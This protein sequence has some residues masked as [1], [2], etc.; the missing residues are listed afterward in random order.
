MN[1]KFTNNCKTC[2]FNLYHRENEAHNDF[3]FIIELK[4][5]DPKLKKKFSYCNAEIFANLA[6]VYC[7]AKHNL[8]TNRIRIICF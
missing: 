8:D 6:K 2:R 1:S 3:H 4:E 7:Y 5:I